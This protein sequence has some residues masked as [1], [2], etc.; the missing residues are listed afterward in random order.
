MRVESCAV[1]SAP[2]VLEVCT[3]QGVSSVISGSVKCTGVGSVE[4]FGSGPVGMMMQ[5]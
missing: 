4:G 2:G 3:P 1:Q 5:S